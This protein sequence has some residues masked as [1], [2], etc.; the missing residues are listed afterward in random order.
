[1]DLLQ[2]IIELG[3]EQA[4]EDRDAVNAGGF[5]INEKRAVAHVCTKLQ[6]ALMWKEQAPDFYEGKRHAKSD[7]RPIV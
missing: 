1:M 3:L 2:Q 5:E 7:S 6:E 4:R